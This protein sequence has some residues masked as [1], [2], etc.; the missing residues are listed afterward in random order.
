MSDTT[1]LAIVAAIPGIISTILAFIIRY[2]QG[3]NH[4]EM[5]VKM[6]TLTDTTNAKMDKLLEV[7]G[8]AEHARGVL[9]GKMDAAETLQVKT[10]VTKRS[11]G[12]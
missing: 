6:Q 11:S 7:T 12:L 10:D 4:D 5:N 2:R 3:I 9:E 8:T 1:A